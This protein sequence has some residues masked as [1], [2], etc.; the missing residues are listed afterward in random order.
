[1]SKKPREQLGSTTLWRLVS[2]IMAFQLLFAAFITPVAANSNTEE[3]DSTISIEQ[4]INWTDSMSKFWVKNLMENMSYSDIPEYLISQHHTDNTCQS[5]NNSTNVDSDEDGISD[6]VETNGGQPIDTDGDGIIDSHDTDSDNDGILDRI[7]GT[8]DRDGDGIADYRD[9]DSDGDREPDREEKAEDTD[10]SKSEADKNNTSTDGGNN[11]EQNTNESV[12]ST[13]TNEEI[14]GQ[15]TND[16][17]NTKTSTSQTSPSDSTNSKTTNAQ[18]T[19]SHTSGKV[20][21]TTNNSTPAAPST[22]SAQNSKSQKLVPKSGALPDI[23]SPVIA[24]VGL[25]CVLGGAIAIARSRN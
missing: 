5:G 18:S 13:T 6:I 4:L 3:D 14:G 12:S 17:T 15:T 23:N 25:L 2:L 16:G 11:E 8:S 24:V 9:L 21:T 1:M 10:N 7:E 20:G 19:E 22:K